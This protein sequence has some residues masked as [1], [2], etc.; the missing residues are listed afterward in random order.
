MSH[1]GGRPRRRQ[2]EAVDWFIGIT[3][4][5]KVDPDIRAN[6]VARR[7]GGRRQDVLRLVRAIRE[8]QSSAVDA[9]RQI[10]SET[11]PSGTRKEG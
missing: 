10:G 8:A 3:V 9:D 6:E 1:E 5:L 11:P 2:V 4:E 7:L